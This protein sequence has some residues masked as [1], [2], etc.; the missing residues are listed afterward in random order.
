MKKTQIHM[1]KPA[2]SELSIL[3]LN[4]IVVYEFWHDYVKSKY[5]EKAK[6]CYMKTDKFIVYIKTGDIYKDIAEVVETKF[7]IS[8]YPSGKKTLWQYCNDASVYV[9]KTLQVPHK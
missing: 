3:E 6:L 7:D 2:F 8:N 4:K 9:P 5:R 1:N